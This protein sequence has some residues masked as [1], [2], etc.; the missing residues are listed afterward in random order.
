MKEIFI[1]SLIIESNSE[2]DAVLI[3]ERRFLYFALPSNQIA[4]FIPEGD[5][6]IFSDHL[7]K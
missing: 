2:F 7:T 6:Y 5:L 1:F 4:S 3:S